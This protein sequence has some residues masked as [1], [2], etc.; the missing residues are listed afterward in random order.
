FDAH[1]QANVGL[2][3]RMLEA[4][5][6]VGIGRLLLASSSSVY[7]EGSGAAPT[8]EPTTTAPISPYGATKA[9]TELLVGAYAARGVPAVSLRY[10][11]VYGRLQRPDMALHRL[12]DAGLGG[13]PFPL[14]GDGSQVRDMTHVDDIVDGT[15]AA[16]G[17]ALQPGTVLNLGSGRPLALRDVHEACATVLCRPIPVTRVAAAPGD[18][19][20]TWADIGRARHLLGWQPR[21]QLAEGIAD[22]VAWQRS[23]LGTAVDVPLVS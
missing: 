11:T 17:A 3:Q 2:A 8:S 20:H 13:P 19:Q 10:F 23:S 4:A 18:P 22:Q 5:L 14:R 1:L 16:M 6:D 7:G 9:A 12:I 15:V 21:V